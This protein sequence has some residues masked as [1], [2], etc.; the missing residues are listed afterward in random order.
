M[1][2]ILT[3]GNGIQNPLAA[4]KGRVHMFGLLVH[5]RVA[6]RAKGSYM[7]KCSSI[8]FQL[9]ELNLYN[10]VTGKT[11]VQHVYTYNTLSEMGSPINMSVFHSVWGREYIY[12][13]FICS[14]AFIYKN[15]ST[16]ATTIRGRARG[17]NNKT[18]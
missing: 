11:C 10:T 3:A 13:K 1:H 14:A 17:E 2:D 4:S 15:R 12:G 7:S 8:R 5:I 6:F 9:T 18:V 16:R